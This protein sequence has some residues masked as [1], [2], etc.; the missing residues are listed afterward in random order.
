MEII[1][2]LANIDSNRSYMKVISL[3]DQ[4][5]T[6]YLTLTIFTIDL[7]DSCIYSM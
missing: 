5:I 3:F 4:S 2:D 6:V 1:E 7:T